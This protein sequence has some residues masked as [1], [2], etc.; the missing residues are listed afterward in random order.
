MKSGILPKILL[1]AVGLVAIF[2]WTFTLFAPSNLHSLHADTPRPSFSLK[3]EQKQVAL[4][5][6]DS[7]VTGDFASKPR[8]GFSYIVS[9][10]FGLFHKNLS[11]PGSGYLGNREY[12]LEVCGA[13]DCLSLLNALEK[14]K[15]LKADVIFV[16]AGLNDSGFESEDSGVVENFYE[17]LR[18]TYPS[19]IVIS[20][21]PTHP[22]S[23]DEY[24]KKIQY[25][26]KKYVT[27]IGGYYVDLGEPLVGHPEWLGA[28]HFHPNDLGY[29]VLANLVIEKTTP[30]IQKVL[31]I[32]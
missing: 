9:Q 11:E 17:R 19:S 30:I 12:A 24:L 14:K 28:D 1:S 6:G 16:Q 8:K 27:Q 13:E 21:S 4:W 15:M 20:L 25:F 10:H 31:T 5:F 26:A 2:L 18:V 22:Y 29:E 23:E 3:S 7:F 32:D